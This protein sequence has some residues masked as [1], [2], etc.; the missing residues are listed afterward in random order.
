MWGVPVSPA[1]GRGV[2][3]GSIRIL[4][5]VRRISVV[6]QA[7]ACVPDGGHVGSWCWCVPRAE[8]S[9]RCVGKAVVDSVPG[10]VLGVNRSLSD[11]YQDA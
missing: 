4:V 5:E 7:V 3:D 2:R 9:P 1:T 11:V 8:V 6:R 10:D